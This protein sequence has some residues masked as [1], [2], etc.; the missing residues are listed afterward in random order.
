MTIA[1]VYLDKRGAAQEALKDYFSMEFII[2]NHS[3]ELAEAQS[4]LTACR[5]AS[6][7]G[8]PSSGNPQSGETRLAAGIDNI[9]ILKERY[10]Q[11]LEYVLERGAGRH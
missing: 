10:R 3:L 4:R 7:S 2:K 11:A 9:D 1:W 5:S 8:L 6:F